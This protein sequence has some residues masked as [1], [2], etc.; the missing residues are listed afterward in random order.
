MLALASSIGTSTDASFFGAAFT[1]VLTDGED[2]KAV[3]RGCSVVTQPMKF[4]GYPESVAIVTSFL[5]HFLGGPDFVSRNAGPACRPS[6]I[7]VV[8][9]CI[10]G[11]AA[12]TATPGVGD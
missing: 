4:M 7:Y 10:G 6:G 1:F 3:L 2:A 9:V 8:F 11:G 12:T 5:C